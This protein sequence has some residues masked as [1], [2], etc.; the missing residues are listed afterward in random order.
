MPWVHCRELFNNSISGTIPRELGKL[1]NLVSLDLYYNRLRGPIPSTLGNLHKLRFLYVVS[2]PFLLIFRRERR[3]Y[4]RLEYL[5]CRRLHMNYL[6]GH[7][8]MSLTT[9]TTLEVLYV[10]IYFFWIIIYCLISFSFLIELFIYTCSDLSNNR[11]TGPIPVNGSFSLFTPSRSNPY[12]LFCYF[13][14]YTMITNDVV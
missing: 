10:I 1:E 3:W 12:S 11:L 14:V 4:E 13:Q 7:I 6:S 5:L 9:I 2:L 8:P